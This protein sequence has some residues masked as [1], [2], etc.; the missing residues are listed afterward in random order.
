[1]E[2][3]TF[4]IAADTYNVEPQTHLI[5]KRNREIWIATEWHPDYEW[6]LICANGENRKHSRIIF[7]IDLKEYLVY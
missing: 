4:L 1:M 2:K 7:P 5:E 3:I 6:A